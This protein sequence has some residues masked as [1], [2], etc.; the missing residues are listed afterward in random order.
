[1]TMTSLKHEGKTINEDTLIQNGNR[2]MDEFKKQ[3]E[4]SNSIDINNSVFLTS[5]GKLSLIKEEVAKSPTEFKVINNKLNLKQGAS[6]SIDLST[7]NIKIKT[8]TFTKLSPAKSPGIV[9]INLVLEYAGAEMT[10]TESF[11]IKKW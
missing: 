1:M 4:G 5:L 7:P 2:I 6:G 9:K 10:F 11:N 3:I 8:L